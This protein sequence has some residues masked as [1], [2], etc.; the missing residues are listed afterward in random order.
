[1]TTAPPTTPKP[2]RRWLQFSLRALIIVM[3]LASVAMSWAAVRMQARKQKRAVEELRRLGG[4]VYERQSDAFGNPLP[5]K[6]MPAWLRNL[7]GDDF[8]AADVEVIFSPCC[9]SSRDGLKQLKGLMQVKRLIFETPVTD[10]D[11]VRWTPETG[12]ENKVE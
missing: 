12:P 2:R 6:G 4:V 3:L 10:A 1:M 8:F 11:L 9:T 5:R 7:L